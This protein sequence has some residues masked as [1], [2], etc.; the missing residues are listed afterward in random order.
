VRYVP[1]AAAVTW[2]VV[3]FTLLTHDIHMG[4]GTSAYDYGIYDQGVWL[5]SR[6]KSPFVT[7]MGRNLF[8]DHS[9]FILFLLVPLYWVVPGAG[10]LLGSQ[11]L[12]IGLGAV[13]V[14]LFA[15]E[16]L[17]SIAMATVLGV[18]FLL[19]PAVGWT[20]LEQ[21][22]PDAFLSLT[23]GLALYGALTDRRKTLVVGVVLS[24]LVK[25]DVVLLM[26]PLG[27]WL[28]FRRR[29]RLGLAIA[30]GSVCYAA[31]ATLV[32]IRG[33][34]GK[35]TLNAWRIPFGGP[36]GFAKTAFEQPGVVWTYLTQDRRPFYFWQ[37]ISSAGL[38]FLAAPDVAFI[39]IGVFASNIVSSFVYQHLIQYHY[40]LIIV[41]VLLFA[42][43]A[44]IQR[45]RTDRLRWIAVGVVAVLACTTAYMW[46]PMPFSRNQ[47]AYWKPDYPD[48]VDARRVA[49]EIPAH[50]VVSAYHSYVP[51]VARRERVYMFPT[52]F[53]AQ[54][55]GVYDREGQTLSF[56][57]DVE[58]VFIPTALTSP[59]LEQ[60]WDAWKDRYV[61]VKRVGAAS[62]YRLRSP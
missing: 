46:G 24:L 37:M 2:Y 40:S 19:H 61:L 27:L 42:T 49:H 51:H 18:V 34:I 60:I 30:I 28:V 23:V 7:V 15:R 25:E 41:P 47:L 4:L 13:P 45:L 33:F 53:H 14:F 59:E 55:W 8:G 50:A 10:V 3:H 62:L 9:S 32:V 36:T 29:T 54:S 5:L 43:V 57:D 38:V 39:A 12:V 1:F 58:Y 22:H 35:P 20:N 21:Y 6:F 52:P 11:S 31:F 26:V 17:G 48:A 16:R 56:V 44:A